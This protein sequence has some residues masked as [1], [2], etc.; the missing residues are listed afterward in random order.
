MKTIKS[1]L[2]L[3]SIVLSVYASFAFAQDNLYPSDRETANAEAGDLIIKTGKYEIK[4][5]V[6]EA[7]YGTLFV[8]E[9][10]HNAES[11]TI[12]LPVIRIKTDNQTA[13]EPVF[14][15][16]GGPGYPNVYS[17]EGTSRF[18]LD[19]L[20][21][22]F[23]AHHDFVMVG[24]RGVDGS[25][26]LDAP[27]VVEALRNGKDL[28]SSE[29]LQELGEALNKALQRMQN[30][31]IDLDG[32]TVKE[33]IDD[34]EAARKALSYKRI[35][36]IGTSYGT[37]LGYVYSVK[38]PD[39]I[40]RSIMAAGSPP[41]GQVLWEPEQVDA[42]LESYG[43]L[44]QES[45]E[46]LAKSPDIVETIRNV[47]KDLPKEWNGI[48]I[49]SGNVKS[50]FFNC[51]Y[52]TSKAAQAFDAFVAAE[53][54]DYSGMAFM[55]F[56]WGQQIPTAINFG[57]LYLKIYSAGI[58]DP[59]RDYESE[60]SSRSSVIGS[61]F[62]KTVFGPAKY[63]ELPI[64]TIP[65]RL[66]QP[67]NIN[68]ETL[69]VCG[70]KDHNPYV[71]TNKELLPYYKN[72]KFVLLSEMGHSDIVFTGRQLGAFYHLAV[73]YYQDGTVDDSRFK[74]EPVNFT[75]MKSFQEMAQEIL[76]K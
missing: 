41:H 50:I 4:G 71:L 66:I 46:N 40:H 30:E 38:Y 10:R 12:N 28:L 74:Y 45:P 18:N 65:K 62:T 37:F 53:N 22:S 35:N 55:S 59:L 42:L 14:Y 72:G 24:Y 57:D 23:L 2:L 56:V 26:S 6:Y 63:L 5:K 61:P 52:E 34:M 11:R 13:N 19:D 76:N 31:G 33:V 60:M 68:V 43:Q 29:S 8:L 7:D 20:Q 58:H 64:K 67:Q 3:L 17:P 51:L 44:W 70:S 75:P 69:F 36:L 49:Y 16:H 9:N 1:K 47:L 54:G 39:A 32:Y 25:V 73:S 27:E 15:F 21:E 48:P